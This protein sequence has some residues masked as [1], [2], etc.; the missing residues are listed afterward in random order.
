[1]NGKPPIESF[2]A[3][4][5]KLTYVG[6]CGDRARDGAAVEHEAARS[7]AEHRHRGGEPARSGTHDGDVDRL[8]DFLRHHSTPMI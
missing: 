6:Y 8:L 2:S 1:M 5:K 7:R 3:V 4:E